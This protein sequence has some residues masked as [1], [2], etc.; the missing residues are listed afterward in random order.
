MYLHIIQNKLQ[1]TSTSS[2]FLFDNLYINSKYHDENIIDYFLNDNNILNLNN[3]DIIKKDIIQNIFNKLNNNHQNILSVALFLLIQ[4]INYEF[5]DNNLINELEKNDFLSS[6]ELL[7]LL[8]PF[9]NYEELSNLQSLSDICNITKSNM[10]DNGI[11]K[12]KYSNLKY[13]LKNTDDYRNNKSLIS[14]FLINNFKLLIKT[15]QKIKNNLYVNWNH[16]FPI[17]YDEIVNIKQYQEIQKMIDINFNNQIIFHHIHK[18]KLY[19][20]S[21]FIYDIFSNQLFYSIKNI[22]WCIYEIPNQSD[23]ENPYKFINILNDYLPLKECLNPKNYIVTDEFNEA[24]DILLNNYSNKNDPLLNSIF[25]ILILFYANKSNDKG[26]KNIILDEDET[27]NEDF[28]NN[29][30]INYDNIIEKITSAKLFSYLRNCLFKL[31][32]TYYAKFLLNEDHSDINIVNENSIYL[33]TNIENNSIKVININ[34]ITIKNVYNY[35]KSLTHDYNN[36]QSNNFNPYFISNLDNIQEDIISRLFDNS[37]NMWFNIT[38]NLAYLDI[39][40]Y[41]SDTIRTYINYN[42]HHI[43][44]DILHYLG[45]LSKFDFNF[46]N[47]MNVEID[48]NNNYDTIIDKIQTEYGDV[49]YFVDNIPYKYKTFLDNR[50]YIKKEKLLSWTNIKTYAMTWISQ[51]NFYHKYI[52]NRVTLLTGSTGVGKSTQT[53]KLLLY[54]LKMI[55]YLNDGTI[56]CTQPRIDPTIKN[57]KYIANEMFV[58]IFDDEEELDYSGNITVL[59][60]H[61]NQNDSIVQSIYPGL[62]FKVVTDGLLLTNIYNPLLKNIVNITN[63]N[64]IYGLTNIYDIVMIDEVHEHNTNMDLILSQ[65]KYITYYNNQIKLVIISATLDDDE[66]IFRR[67]YNTVVDDRKYPLNVY[68]Q[69]NAISRYFVDR[70]IN[71]S[72]LSSSTKYNIN[73]FYV[74]DVDILTIIHKIL[75]ES[76]DGDILIF[77]T[78]EQ[79][80]KNLVLNINKHT[81][82]NII[83]IPFYSNLSGIKRKYIS[84]IDKNNKFFPQKNISF[85]TYNDEII[86]HYTKNINNGN[87]IKYDRVIIVATNIAEASITLKDLE[88]VI[89]IGKQ[90]KNRFDIDLQMNVLEEGNISEQSRIQRKGRIGRVKEGSIYYLY[91]KNALVNDN[92]INMNILLENFSYNLLNLLSAY[93]DSNNAYFTNSTDPNIKQFNVNVNDKFGINNIIKNQYY[94]NDVF[95]DYEL[96]DVPGIQYFMYYDNKFDIHTLIDNKGIFYIIHPNELCFIRNYDGEIISNKC[97][98]TNKMNIFIK[99]LEEQLFIYNNKITQFG[100][101]IM[102]NAK[103]NITLFSS[104]NYE[105]HI[106]IMYAVKYGVFDEIIKI[107]SVL[108]YVRRPFDLL[109]FDKMTRKNMNNIKQK[110]ITNYTNNFGDIHAY[111]NFFNDVYTH[112]KNNTLLDWIKLNN[113]NSIVVN[114]IINFYT[115]YKTNYKINKSDLKYF[116]D[117]TDILINVNNKLEFTLSLCFLLGFGNNNLVRYLSTIKTQPY[118]L[119]FYKPNLEYIFSLDKNIYNN[120]I[121]SFIPINNIYP[122]ILFLYQTVDDDMFYD[123]IFTIIN[124]PEEF[125]CALPQTIILNKDILNTT[126]Q[127]T[128]LNEYIKYLAEVEDKNNV[129]NTTDFINKYDYYINQLIKLTSIN[130]YVYKLNVI[131]DNFKYY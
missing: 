57:A 67:F 121:T 122:N 87:L 27:D 13:S 6:K 58:P 31:K 37:N 16:I 95:Y 64:F 108:E 86:E 29:I 102:K 101:I 129:A 79:E 98:N 118:Y 128:Y 113:Y 104:N 45:L 20:N 65:M 66:P 116:P 5:N 56:I 88:Y 25:E 69:N 76:N 73:E 7:L 68:N 23:A 9:I 46:G 40:T 63:D 52:N 84:N 131:N 28:I 19:E 55:D 10:N 2:N 35:A 43:C 120:S 15:I 61:G 90:K 83:A 94:S 92:K 22:K 38:G 81:P 111:L 119:K 72:P 41:N 80:I 18:D 50:N 117:F 51:I 49:N 106:V 11:I 93:N 59:Y 54:G 110:F 100:K 26:I 48:Y 105:K 36:P 115:N 53:P 39:T 99:I 124:I 1:T 96:L 3:I 114:K 127:N 33:N 42:L 109:S 30:H 125:I 47:R 60:E 24:Y 14:Y 107:L 8:L 44:Y 75:N 89:D 103:N 123:K 82:N 17:L 4:I 62:K 97:K 74:K 21:E 70:R 32:T 85:D 34:N 77:A 78:G 71:I 12:Y 130:P 126:Y 91:E 112:H